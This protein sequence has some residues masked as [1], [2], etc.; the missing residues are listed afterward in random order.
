MH[1]L[2]LA[3]RTIN[4]VKREAARTARESSM[5]ALNATGT[6]LLGM[7]AGLGV[8]LVIAAQ[9]LDVGGT[10]SQFGPLNI[11]QAGVLLLVIGLVGSIEIARG[12]RP[13]RLGTIMAGIALLAVLLAVS[14]GLG[15][16]AER[17]RE[18]QLQYRKQFETSSI[19][20]PDNPR[21]ESFAPLEA[22]QRLRGPLEDVARQV[23]PDRFPF[24]SF[25]SLKEQSEPVE[26]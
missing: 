14:V 9:P 15:R 16:R 7:L 26:A 21:H 11:F 1:G 6:F 22:A 24:L 3:A 25:R 5:T 18:L 12:L 13:R 2:H 4:D 10:V 8:A 19:I 20:V 23:A 17:F